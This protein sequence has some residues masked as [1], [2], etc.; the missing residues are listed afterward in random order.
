VS[1]SWH[2]NMAAL[3]P[4]KPYSAV[5]FCHHLDAIAFSAIGHEIRSLCSILKVFAAGSLTIFKLAN[6]P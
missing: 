4:P 3:V 1:F 6:H 5:A 2:H